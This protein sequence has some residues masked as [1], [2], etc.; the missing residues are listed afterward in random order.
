[1]YALRTYF[2]RSTYLQCK[3]VDWNHCLVQCKKNW[4]SFYFLAQEIIC[5]ISSLDRT[6]STMTSWL[7]IFFSPRTFIM[8]NT[9]SPVSPLIFYTSITMPKFTFI[10]FL[11]HPM[12]KVNSLYM[13]SFCCPISPPIL[14]HIPAICCHHLEFINP[15]TFVL[16]FTH[17]NPSSNEKW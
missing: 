11:Q 6:M 3:N 14:F 17:T 12:W 13:H 9:C 5:R 16:L 10:L 1:M 2:A 8:F 7:T 15:S 4:P